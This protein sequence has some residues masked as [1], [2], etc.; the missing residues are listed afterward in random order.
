MR[1][2]IVFAWD[3]PRAR[4]L[5]AQVQQVL[6]DVAVAFGH[7]FVMKDERMGAASVEAYGSAMTVETVEAC[8][9]ADATL[10]VLTHPDGLLELAQGLLCVLAC[11]LYEEWPA[12]CDVPLASGLMPQGVICY[13]LYADERLRDAAELAYALSGHG[14][15]REIPFD[16]SLRENWLAATQALSARYTTMLPVQVTLNDVLA[17]L[18]ADPTGLGV[19]FAKP[20]AA[21]TLAAAADALCGGLPGHQRFMGDKCLHVYVDS[22]AGVNSLSPSALAAAADLLRTSLNLVREADCVLAATAN[23][24]QTAP[25]G[26]LD[27]DAWERVSQQIA[28]AGELLHPKS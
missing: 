4:S 5:Q 28:L 13:P 25:E 8:Q 15:V 19:V 9:E 14:R 7:S 2:R 11:H 12:G 16:G 27:I 23:V 10:A 20:Q 6:S 17:S 21:Q 24:Q 22:Q 3:T 18:I 1:A 26:G